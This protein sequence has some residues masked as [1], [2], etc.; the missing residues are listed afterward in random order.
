MSLSENWG[1]EYQL[2]SNSNE[3]ENRWDFLRGEMCFDDLPE[4]KHIAMRLPE[5]SASIWHVP[6]Y[7]FKGKRRF[8]SLRKEGAAS[9][10]NNSTLA[11][12]R[13]MLL[14]LAWK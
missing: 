11:P 6:S 2:V 8:P 4:T 13:W 5:A 1:F 10:Y 3:S 7:T 9:V 12:N 14:C